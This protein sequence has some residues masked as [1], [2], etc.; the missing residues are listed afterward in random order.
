MMRSRKVPPSNGKSLTTA[1][2]V[3][4]EH[5]TVLRTNDGAQCYGLSYTP[6]GHVLISSRKISPFLFNGEYCELVSAQYLL[7]N[8]YRSYEPILMRFR[9]PDT[10]SP[11]DKGGLNA[12]CYVKGDPVN[13]SD[14]TGKS[15]LGMV[16]RALGLVKRVKTASVLAEHIP[17]ALKLG[18]RLNG[19]IIAKT[20]HKITRKDVTRIGQLKGFV[21]N[22]TLNL[23]TNS[24]WRNIGDVASHASQNIGGLGITSTSRHQIKGLIKDGIEMNQLLLNQ[25]RVRGLNQSRKIAPVQKSYLGDGF[26]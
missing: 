6:F 24:P 25:A 14:P 3:T 20:L 17:A 11:F 26:S 21:N 7:G 13:Y 4:D 18:P 19:E 12:Y 8:G 15:L 23:P 2:L 10:Y 5:K 9:S 1:L 22:D 16:G